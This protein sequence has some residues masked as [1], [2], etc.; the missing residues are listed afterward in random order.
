MSAALNTQADTS[1]QSSGTVP[2]ISLGSFTSTFSTPARKL[3]IPSA[4][5][6][7]TAVSPPNGS[8]AKRRAEEAT[9]I[10]KRFGHADDGE[11]EDG[12]VLDTPDGRKGSERWGDTTTDVSAP[13][14]PKRTRSAG[15]KGGTNLTLRDQ[16]KHIDA[17][18]KENFNIKLKVHFLEERLAQLA[19]DQIDA[20]LKQNINLKIEVQQR[21]MEIKKLKKLVLELQRELEHS[22]RAGG[23]QSR[24]RELEEKLAER[25][26]ELRE[27]RRRRAIG[28]DDGASRELEARN[29]ELEEELGNVRGLL[30]ENTEELERL[31]EL[32]ESRDDHSSLGSERWRRQAEELEGEN[33]ELR[34][35]IDELE[36]LAVQRTDER[37]DLADEVEAL[38]LELEDLQRRREAESIERSH[39]R[40]Q[41]LEEREGREAIEEDLNAVRDKLA[42]AQIELQ[43]KEDE[44]DMKHREIE[45]LI[46]E[47]QRIVESVEEEWRGEVD[48]AKGQMEELRDALEQRDAECKELRLHIDEYEA[49]AEDLHQK[50]EAT[51]VHLEREA[52]EKDNELEA[53]NRDLEKMSNQLYALEEENER[54]KEEMERVREDEADERDRLEQLSAAL[55]Q[56]VAQLKADL[57]ELTDLY[58][59]RDAEAQEHRARKEELAQHIEKVVQELQ[60]ERAVRE[61]LE[62]DFDKAG[63]E[64]DDAIR[65]ERRALEAKESALQSALNDLARA[66]SL[67]TQREADLAAVQ[68]ALQTLEADNKKLGESHTTARFSLQLEVDRLRRDVERL[69]DELARARKELDDREGKGRDRDGVIDKLYVE[70]R[71]LATQLAAET[72]ARLNLSEKLDGTQAS[73]HTAESETAN[74]RTRV[75]ELE[76]R[77]SKDQRALLAAEA[78]YRDQL[79][80][81]NTLLLTI[82]QY[83]D[84]IVGVD[85]TPKKYGQAETKPFTNFSVFHDNLITRLKALSQI[86][87]D[88]EKRV[89]E[90]EQRYSD[91]LNDMRKQ[92]DLRWKQI[93]KFEASVKTLAE[94]KATWR[95]KLSAKEGEIEALQATNAALQSAVVTRKGNQADSMEIRA[96]TARAQ[97]AER[98][99]INLQ[100]QLVQSEEKLTAVN[101]KTTVADS[102]WEARVKEYETRL[103][104]AEEKIKREKQ[105]GKERASELENQL[106][107]L[108]RQLELA[109][110]R[111]STLN[112]IIETAGLSAKGSPALGK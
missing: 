34:A 64:H 31:R 18:K 111:T 8:F 17:L 96:L 108:Q 63:K 65:Q 62:V 77:L 21:G 7:T 95:K 103:K 83:M 33:E 47:H 20:A 58:N 79:T 91:K 50:F 19:P 10:S 68:T 46:A 23:A 44:I 74:L 90:A 110:K 100:N 57:Q 39:S 66:Q 30:E 70:N 73:L 85:K 59:T 104:T 9:P 61:R 109:N 2:D 54:L 25:E 112:E 75:A 87:S 4:S 29:A 15:T 14:R 106:K 93:D 94:A 102:K 37:D 43:Q 16:E 5:T 99:A 105:G 1:A 86:Q 41:I 80:E 69:E 3:R 67:L 97:N 92:L 56:K 88:F 35:R 52:E 84:K 53:A 11:E 24:A 78:Q 55:K 36:E 51:L 48:E 38:R 12:D 27:L 89:K 98:R 60:R 32:A 107:S 101:Q 26:Q 45:E 72:Q 40:A 71:D 28:P 6:G 82:Y 49:N 22:Q 81:R 42:A 76:Q 13:G